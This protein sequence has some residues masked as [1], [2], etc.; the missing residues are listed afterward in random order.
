MRDVG[1][2]LLVSVRSS[3][4][5]EAALE[6]GAQLIDV[7]EPRHGSLG[8]AD[9]AVIVDVIERV[10]GRRPVSAALGELANPEQAR[11]YPRPGLAYG[12]WG[13]SGMGKEAD[14]QHL[15]QDARRRVAAVHAACQVVLVAYADWPRAAA[16]SVA[17]VSAFAREQA[18]GVLLVD[19]FVKAPRHTLL[20]QMPPEEICRLCASCRAAGVRVALAG[21]LGAAEIERLKPARPDWFAVRGAACAGDRRE[22]AVSARKVRE[23]VGLL[24][25]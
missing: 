16:P 25:E 14:W 5:A 23:L 8:R 3:T 4:E 18:G 24:Q 17:A 11:P 10:A 21:S 2:Q 19:T 6:G 13:L 20:H 9:E 22:A 12:K 1:P 7:K 15:W